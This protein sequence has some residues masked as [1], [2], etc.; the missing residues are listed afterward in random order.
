MDGHPSNAEWHRDRGEAETPR[1]VRGFAEVLADP[2]TLLIADGGL[3]SLLE[4]RGHDLSGGLWS[5]RLLT[6]APKEIVAAH[7]AFF[8]A[9]AT[10][11]ITASYQASI[12]GF[13]A[14]GYGRDE[15]E[16][17]LGLSVE[18]A[19]QARTRVAS[20]GIARWIAASIG[21]YGAALADG[22]EFRGR[23]GLSASELRAWH[24]PR[25]Q[26]LAEAGPDV[27]A[28]ETIPDI[29]EAEVLVDLVAEA[30]VPAWLSYTID[31][32]HTRA[33]QP[34]SEAFAVAA[35]APDIVAVGVNC[36]RPADVG[37]A[38]ETARRVT[39]KSVVVYPN[40]GE[41]WD[42]ERQS[43]TGTS[44]F[45]ADDARA[46]AT[47]GAEIIG[48]CCR[49]GPADIAALSRS[50]GFHQNADTEPRRA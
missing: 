46:W 16:R 50:L 34:L 27:L 8:H 42:A 39:G 40:S 25:L 37:P 32:A 9:G 24:R 18:L 5:A 26:V 38:V 20:E 3:A 35:D 2:G 7:A 15:G 19:R 31:G 13:A 1:A 30:G 10:I 6:D 14:H 12:G 49:V 28:L 44:R 11:A 47:N 45:V 36:C 21:P 43:W 29:D 17:L 33:G 4:T 41:G 48:G 22:S 23:Y